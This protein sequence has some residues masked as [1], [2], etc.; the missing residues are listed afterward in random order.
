MEADEEWLLDHLGH[1]G[2]CAQA[3]SAILEASACY[4]AWQLPDAAAA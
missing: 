3:H 2:G 4:R 1:C